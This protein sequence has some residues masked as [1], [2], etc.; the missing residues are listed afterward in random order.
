MRAVADSVPCCPAARTSAHGRERAGAADAAW[1]VLPGS[2]RNCLTAA[3]KFVAVTSTDNP[4]ARM[5]LEPATAE[6]AR[7]RAR[8]GQQADVERPG[9]EPGTYGLKA[10]FVRFAGSSTCAAACRIRVVTPWVLR[11]RRLAIGRFFGSSEG[12]APG[13]KWSRSSD[14]LRVSRW[15]GAPEL[16]LGRSRSWRPLRVR[17]ALPSDSVVDRLMPLVPDNR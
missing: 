12:H 8:T 16:V 11:F 6:G 4:T 14:R 7:H 15:V 3:P 5:T 10:R 2:P 9:L 1:Q 17:R 13:G